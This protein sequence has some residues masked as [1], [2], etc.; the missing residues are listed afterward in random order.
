[1]VLSPAVRI[2]A[3]L[4]LAWT[5]AGPA[6]AQ[7]KGDRGQGRG[8][9]K[10]VRPLWDQTD[11]LLNAGRYAEAE[12]LARKAIARAKQLG[13]PGHRAVG[14]GYSDLGK[15]L[16]NLNRLAEAEVAARHALAIRERENGKVSE[17]VGGT[18]NVLARI[19][20]KQGKHEEAEQYFTC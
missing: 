9:G 4:V 7:S 8:V 20:H 13:G 19:L 11:E 16:L 2:V 6:A 14:R 5:I 3:V 12:A 10:H 15:A 18:S 1:V 17:Q